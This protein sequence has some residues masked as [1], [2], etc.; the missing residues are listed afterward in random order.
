MRSL[1]QRVLTID[2][3]QEL[4]ITNGRPRLDGSK[5]IFDRDE[6]LMRQ[7]VVFFGS[8]GEMVTEHVPTGKDDVGVIRKAVS[9]HPCE[10]QSIR[11]GDALF[12][13]LDSGRHCC[14]YGSAKTHNRDSKL[15]IR[16]KRSASL[17]K[18]I[19]KN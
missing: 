17:Q 4:R 3:R 19:T 18:L 12:Q 14:A 2:I 10:R 6:L 1:R 16:H 5:R 7:D 15:S 13:K 9:S 8:F 11:A